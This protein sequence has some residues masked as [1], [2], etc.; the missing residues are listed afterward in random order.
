LG[1]KNLP[2]LLSE[3]NGMNS[4]KAK[5]S[6]KSWLCTGKSLVLPIFADVKLTS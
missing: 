3:Q 4:E 5:K 1:D 2:V 6:T